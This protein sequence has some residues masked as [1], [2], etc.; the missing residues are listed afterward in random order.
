MLFLVP[1]GREIASAAITIPRGRPQL[2]AER[3]TFVADNGELLRGPY[4]STEWTSATS[5]SE[6]ANMKNL[7]F[8][9]VHLYAEC[10]DINYPAAGSTAPGYKADEVDK[11]VAATRE[12]G[13]Y[14]VITIG[15][16]ANN[17]KHNAKWIHD[18]WAL[19]AARYADETHLLF[20]VQNEPVAW[21]PPYS[22]PNAT[23]P[24]AVQME[25]DVYQT[26]RAAAPDTPILLFSYAV[27]GGKEGGQAALRDIEVFNREVGGD[28][29]EIWSNA[30]I[31]FHGYAGHKD[32]PI[33]VDELLAAGYP[34]V[35]TEYHGG[36]WGGAG[37]LDAELTASLERLGV[38]WLTF[39]TIPPTGVSEFVT[40]PS[41]F[42]DRVE[43]SGLSWTPDFGT[44]PSARGIF[45]NDGLPRETPHTWRDDRLTGVLRLECE[46][47]DAGV[48]GG[49]FHV[50]DPRASRGG[51]YRPK[52]GVDIRPVSDGGSGF[53]VIADDGEWFEYTLYVKEPGTFQLALRYAARRSAELRLLLAGDE[54]ALIAL[55]PDGSSFRTVN[56]NVFLGYGRN[57]LRVEVPKGGCA[58]NWLEFLP[59]EEGPIS[60]GE[61]KIV[62]RNSGLAMMNKTENLDR[63]EILKIEEAN[64]AAGGNEFAKTIGDNVII[65]MPFEEEKMHLWKLEHLGAGQ[66][67]ISSLE[68]NWFWSEAGDRGV[69]LF[70]WGGEN[71]GSN[72][73]FILQKE[74]EGYFSI[75]AVNRGHHI[76]VQDAAVGGGAP[77]ASRRSKAEW[78]QQWAIQEPDATAI[79][80]GLA[81]ERVSDRQ[82]NLTWN[83]VPD[84][85]GYT[86][87]RAEKSGGPYTA[88]PKPTRK[89]A[90]TDPGAAKEKEYFYVVSALGRNGESQ[91]SIEA[92]PGKLHLQYSFDGTGS[93][94]ASDASGNGWDGSFGGSPE[95]GPGVAGKA[96]ILDGEKDYIELPEGIMD[97]LTEF[98]ITAWIHIDV[99]ARWSRLFDF[100][101]STEVYMYLSPISGDGGNMRFSIKAD[102]AERS[103][104]GSKPVPVGEWAHIA[105]VAKEGTGT[106]YLNGES[107]GHSSRLTLTPDALGRTTRNFIGKSQ[108]PDPLLN[109][110]VD[111]FRIYASAISPGDIAMLVRKTSGER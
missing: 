110:S 89:P 82:V 45:G 101:N 55:E 40:E 8:N 88:A 68:N 105:V 17:G 38:S 70:W 35:V 10:Y 62:N 11:I 58:L 104:T 76:G 4:T 78:D 37:G 99:S 7:G 28:P 73:R 107:V 2:N 6:I 23:P 75:S 103:I 91:N 98:S 32:T 72:Q 29:E 90:F 14:L 16:G 39:L 80:T 63:E 100:G 102:G 86:V 25:V 95:R 77:L 49:T 61:Y 69:N 57:V 83:P 5:E 64:N 66:Y 3:T 33:A 108:H 13:L 36:K 21:G 97:G 79:P 85:K 87:K 111:D 42:K 43:Q 92:S 47:Y 44:W 81:S 56:Q 12:L 67:R 41:A 31:G 71:T 54:I 109:A 93:R 60:S 52:D 24:G 15:N 34:C 18:F 50:N 84:T 96:I 46:D 26:I 65:L 48:E 20:E 1:W 19:Y 59:L 22:N 94:S 53:A 106:L 51:N 27:L 9:A 30:A 74:A